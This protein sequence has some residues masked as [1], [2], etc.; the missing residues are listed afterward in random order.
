MET[1]IFDDEEV[2][3]LSHAKGLRIFRFC[4]MLWKGAPEPTIK[5]CLGGQVDVV[6]EFTTIQNF[7]Q[8]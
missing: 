5:Y 1:M 3:S 7:G 6:Q 4:V 8:N 2:S